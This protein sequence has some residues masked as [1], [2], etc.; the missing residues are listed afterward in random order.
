MNV[1]DWL[2]NMEL[3]AEERFDIVEVRF[4]NGRKEFFRNKEKLTLIT[5]DPVVVEVPNGHHIGYV[6]MQ[7]ELVRLQMQK[8]KVAADDQIK[9]IYRLAHQKD[10]EKFEDV[11]KRELPT[12]Y[13]TREIIRS[14][15]LAMKLS[16]VEYQA[17]N[18]KATFFYSADDRVDFRELI[19]MLAA[20]FRIRV[21]MRQ[22]SLR[23]EAGRLGGIGVCGRE[24]CCST[25]LGD[26]RNVT[27]SAARYQ[28]LSLNPSKLSGQCGRLKCC[29]NY[30][31]ETY[32]DALRD[33][34]KIEGP[35]LTERG[36]AALQKTD[37]FRRIMWFGYSEENTWYPLDVQRV[38]E[39][40]R[41]N[42]EGAKPANLEENVVAEKEPIQSLNSDLERMDKKFSNKS[43][44][45]KKKRRDRRGPKPNKRG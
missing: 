18:T 10:L 7:G 4:K 9:K 44:R 12:L 36:A 29:L 27:T 39:I 24:L 15:K 6:S 34:P 11:K 17:D 37:I 28:N 30:E 38:N 33:I 32:M 42:R 21:E 8:K 35:L 25:W 45:K 2:S 1:F 5:G 31:L 20:E 23:Q 3:P 19:K 26:F 41:M 13:R 14:V 16:D 43:R 22:I 40:L